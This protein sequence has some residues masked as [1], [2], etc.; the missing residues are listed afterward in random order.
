VAFLVYTVPVRSVP[1]GASHR[2]RVW[3]KTRRD[4]LGAGAL[5][6]SYVYQRVWKSDA[7]KIGAR[8]DF[9]VL[10]PRIIMG[11]P[12]GAPQTVVMELAARSPVGYQRDAKS[13]IV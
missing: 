6:D 10:G 3:L 5:D 11:S 12:A 13:P 9:E 4:D 1:A 2:L 7:F 8:L